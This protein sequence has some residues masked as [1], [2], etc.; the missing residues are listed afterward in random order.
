LFFFW[1][2]AFLSFNIFRFDFLKI[3]TIF[4]SNI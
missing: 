1:I 2:W 3:W 4:I